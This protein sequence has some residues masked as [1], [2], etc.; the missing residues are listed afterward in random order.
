M[1]PWSFFLPIALAVAL[2]VLVANGLGAMFFGAGESGSAQQVRADDVDADGDAHTPDDVPVPGAKASA[3]SGSADAA[4]MDG[5]PEAEAP[6]ALE[7]VR[8]PGPSAAR[9][10]GLSRACIGGTIAVRATNG[11]EQEVVEDAPAR[12]I[13]ASP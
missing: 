4:D 2:G 9:R 7:P 10:D 11:W 13:A 1:T 6:V 5:K 12:C 3:A 8:L